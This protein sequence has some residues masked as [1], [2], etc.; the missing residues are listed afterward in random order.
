MARTSSMI[1]TFWKCDSSL[2][3]SWLLN[4]RQQRIWGIPYTPK[5]VMFSPTTLTTV[6]EFA[7]RWWI[8]KDFVM[9][10]QKTRSWNDGLG[11]PLRDADHSQ[12]FV[13]PF[14]SRT[15]SPP[16]MAR[17]GTCVRW[18][19]VT[20]ISA[21]L[22]FVSS[23]CLGWWKG[24]TYS[25]S[26]LCDSQVATLRSGSHPQK[27]HIFVADDTSFTSSSLYRPI[28]MVARVACLRCPS[29]TSKDRVC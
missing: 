1:A 4:T 27:L 5:L 3:L 29:L 17:R 7:W 26:M 15:V 28:W 11:G 2:K 22:I 24:R 16:N 25:C 20:Y 10:C 19:W 23:R 21:G 14:G 6:N 12:I 9:F 13:L 8:L 18:A